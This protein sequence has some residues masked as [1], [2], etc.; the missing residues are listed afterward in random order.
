MSLLSWSGRPRSTT[1]SLNGIQDRSDWALSQPD[2]INRV[3]I[4]QLQNGSSGRLKLSNGGL[5]FPRI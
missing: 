2:R 5:G 3:L 4:W 1:L